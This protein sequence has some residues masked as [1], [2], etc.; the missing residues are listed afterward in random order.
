MD[1]NDRLRERLSTD[2]SVDLAEHLHGAQLRRDLA[3][4]PTM[5]ACNR[6]HI[7]ALAACGALE[8]R[9]AAAL[10][11]FHAEIEAQPGRLD[12][13][14]RLEDLYFNVEA[15]ATRALGPETGGRLQLGRSRNDLN[16]AISRMTA[17]DTTLLLAAALSGL[18]TTL[19]DVATRYQDAVMTGYT[20]LQ[21]AQPITFGFYLVSLAEAL[22]RDDERLRGA[23]MRCNRSP[24]GAAALAGTSVPLDR[25]LL[26]T[27]L[28]F[29]GIIVNALDAV[30]SRDHVVELLAIAVSATMTV[31]RLAQDLY[32][33][34]TPEFG[35]VTVADEVAIVSSIMPQKRNPVTLEHCK[36]KAALV[37][38]AFVA[39]ASAMRGAPFTNVR[40]VGR[41]AVRPFAD[42]MAEA[43]DC[44]D[45]MRITL[46][47][48]SF[49]WI[50]ALDRSRRDFSTV[51]ELADLLVRDGALPFRTAHRV[52]AL[53]VRRL[54]DQGLDAS[55]L[56]AATLR[57]AATEIDVPDF[58]VN[59]IALQ[60]ALDPA[61]VVAGRRT[62]GSAAPDQIGGMITAER[63]R[64][65]DDET[66]LGV[67]RERIATADRSL[68]QEVERI[69]ARV[70]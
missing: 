21:P 38:G 7:V 22:A 66:W 67:E 14:P 24:L 53:A 49:D 51:T 18:R 12:P 6:A 11:R 5:I 31:S 41:E 64:L 9:D 25:V 8:E 43:I 58:G 32:V 50:H 47:G 10:L 35:L 40:D 56:D 48:L 4:L 57:S 23:Y 20:H 29:D 30:A 63:L 37:L 16:S 46:A 55:A 36:G 28:G 27:L 13:D 26:A 70:E 65:V 44:L 17:R 1:R 61:D 52:V 2:T 34:S 3:V 68:R 19:L 45:L 42:G 15:A 39:A 69:V 54:A 60:R 59:D 62:A 33:W